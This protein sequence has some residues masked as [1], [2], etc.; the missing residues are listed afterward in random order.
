MNP[1]GLTQATANTEK[2]YGKKRKKCVFLL[3]RAYQRHHIEW[4]GEH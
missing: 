2:L 3:V 1:E 4:G